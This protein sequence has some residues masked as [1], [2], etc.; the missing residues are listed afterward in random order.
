L[1]FETPNRADA[2]EELQYVN[3]TPVR[4]TWRCRA[5]LSVLLPL[6]IGA[7]HQP[8]RAQDGNPKFEVVSIHLASPEARGRTINNLP[9]RILFGNA[10]LTTL[11]EYA[12]DVRTL[13]D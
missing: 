4:L 12:Y 9:A 13:P 1:E 8:A 6:L 11:I 10:T 3:M 2:T 5:G 7:L